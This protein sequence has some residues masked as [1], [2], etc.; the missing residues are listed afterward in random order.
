MMF[1]GHSRQPGLY[2][3]SPPHWEEEGGQDLRLFFYD[4]FLLCVVWV[5]FGT[6]L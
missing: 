2:I 1:N 3:M 4:C 6:Y 5:W